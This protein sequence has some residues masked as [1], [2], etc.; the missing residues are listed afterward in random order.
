MD[1]ELNKKI[2]KEV[3]ILASLSHLNLITYYFAIKSST[4]RSIEFSL[5]E[6]KKE[7]LYIE[8]NLMQKNLNN[9]LEIKEVTFIFLIEIMHQII[10]K[11]Y[12]LYDIHIAHCNLKFENILVNIVKSKVMN[13]IVHILL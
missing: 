4:N 1:V 10:K 12:Y 13:K 3:S 6:D 2:I 8:M 11:M 9:M 5:S 7:S